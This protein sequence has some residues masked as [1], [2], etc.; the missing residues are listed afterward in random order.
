ML[1]PKFALCLALVPT[2][3][4]MT[5]SNPI[6][7]GLSDQAMAFADTHFDVN[8]FWEY[9]AGLDSLIRH[10]TV[11]DDSMVMDVKRSILWDSTEFVEAAASKSDQYYQE[12]KREAMVHGWKDCEPVISHPDLQFVLDSAGYAYRY[13]PH[14][15]VGQGDTVWL[16]TQLDKTTGDTVATY[17]WG[18]SRFRE[19]YL[20][21]LRQ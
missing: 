1:A 10:Q 5:C 4:L 9:C 13:Q 17:L 11:Y 12:I 18:Y 16:L 21:M 19:Q 2:A 7:G 20:E 15:E 3:L 8:R 6:N 14:Q